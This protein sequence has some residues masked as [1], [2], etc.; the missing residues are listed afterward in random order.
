[1]DDSS[2]NES[3]IFFMMMS[4]NKPAS[5][6]PVPPYIPVPVLTFRQPVEKVADIVFRTWRVNADG[7]KTLIDDSSEE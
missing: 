5:C 7:T 3:L 4:Q 2:D 6:E 1:M